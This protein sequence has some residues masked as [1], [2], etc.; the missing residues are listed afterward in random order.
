MTISKETESLDAPW[1]ASSD[2]SFS[3]RKTTSRQLQH[4][5]ALAAERLRRLRGGSPDDLEN[6]IDTD[7]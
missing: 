6:C 7:S 1:V 5:P 4:Q 2:C 3:Q